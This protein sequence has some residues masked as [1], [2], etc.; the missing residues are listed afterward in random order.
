[1]KMQINAHFQDDYANI[2]SWLA[3]TFPIELRAQP[4]DVLLRAAAKRQLVLDWMELQAMIE[5]IKH[6]LNMLKTD[7]IHSKGLHEEVLYYCTIIL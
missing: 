7:F 1:M 2:R 3:A 6:K 5:E 4:D